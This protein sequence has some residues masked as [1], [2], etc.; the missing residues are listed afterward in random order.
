MTRLSASSMVILPLLSLTA[1]HA[2]DN[3]PA[4]TPTPTPA[5]TRTESTTQDTQDK[6]QQPKTER[7]QVTGSRIRQL[8]LEGPKPV[9]TVDRKDLEKSGAVNLNEALNKLTVA[10]FG[11][12]EYGSNYG[13]PEGTQTVDLRGLGEGNTLVLLNGR[14]IVRDPS[15]EFI[16]LSVIPTAAVERVEIITGTA[17]AIYGTDALAGVINIITRKQYDGMSFGYSMTKPRFGGGDRDQVYMMAG[18]NSEKT[19]NLITMQW[20]ESKPILAKDR[21]WFDTN[22]RS[23]RGAPFS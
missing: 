12:G 21:P 11:S 19:S 7:I 17:S 16:D 2:Q 6:K 4:A 3:T 15:L 14:R 8:D 23:S 10:S 13:A 20:D 9:I 1:V 5:P 22:F 18:T